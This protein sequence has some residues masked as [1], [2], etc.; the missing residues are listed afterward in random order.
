MI[1]EVSIIREGSSFEFIKSTKGLF[2][3]GTCRYMAFHKKPKLDANLTKKGSAGCV[4]KR[5]FFKEI[6]LFSSYEPIIRSH[7]KNKASEGLF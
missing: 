4:P 2:L 1:I 7:H 6:S 5:S 3:T